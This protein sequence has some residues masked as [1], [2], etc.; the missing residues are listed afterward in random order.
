[1]P[2]RDALAAA[3]ATWPAG[4]QPKIPFSS[5]RTAVEQR[6]VR[7]GRRVERRR[8]VPQLRAHA[9]LVDPIAFEG[10]LAHTAG[11]LAFD[12]MLEAK[13]KDL[14][15]LRLREQLLAR[16]MGWREGRLLGT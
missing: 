9:D 10:F 12:V 4:V 2:D 6:V 15:L 8:V 7:K 14:A 16:G 5:P 13:A 1:M 3:L 11:G